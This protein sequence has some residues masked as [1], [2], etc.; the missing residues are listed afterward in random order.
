MDT[1]ID[2]FDKN[3][4]LFHKKLEICRLCEE[5]SSDYI[6]IFE[7]KDNYIPEKINKRLSLFC[8]ITIYL[9]MIIFQ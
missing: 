3:V 6:T 5:K 4:N 8:R 2:Y 1:K 7:H 9:P